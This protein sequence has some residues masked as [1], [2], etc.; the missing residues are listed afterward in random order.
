MLNIVPGQSTTF[1]DIA[2]WAAA[3][4]QI[5][6]RRALARVAELWDNVPLA[7][8]KADLS[9]FER[10]FPLHGFDPNVHKSDAAYK[11][12]RRK[13][14]AILKAYAA[15][16]AP[17]PVPSAKPL[18]EAQLSGWDDLLA[19]I[20]HVTDGVDQDALYKRQRA[21]PIRTLARLARALKLGP[22]DLTVDTLQALAK[23]LVSSERDSLM[24]AL[25]N[26]NLMRAVPE[27]AALLPEAAYP[28]NILPRRGAI[29]ELPQHIAQEIEVW[30]DVSC[31]GKWDPVAQVAMN[32]TS[33]HD[34]DK[35]RIAMRRFCATAFQEVP[36]LVNVGTIAELLTEETMT[37]VLRAWMQEENKPLSA[38][39]ITTY[40]VNIKTVAAHNELDGS[41]FD[42]LEETATVLKAGKTAGKSMSPKTKKFCA[43]LL[44]N[45]ALQ[46]KL[47]TLHVRARRV[48]AMI[49]DR[50]EKEKRDLSA[51]EIGRIRQL[52]AVAAFS[53]IETC[54]AP[55]RIERMTL[56]RISGPKADVL[57]PSQSILT[58]RFLLPEVQNK[59]KRVVAVSMKQDKR[60]GLDTLL[61]YI[62]RV[63]PLFSEA[64]E[65]EYLFPAVQSRG[66]MRKTML[67][68]WF[69]KLSRQ[70]GIPMTPHNFRHAMASMLIKKHPGQYEAVAVL[71]G[72][73]EKTVR[74][75]YAWVNERVQIETAQSLV[76]GLADA[77]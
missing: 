41:V 37:L 11:A 69:K 18:A 42:H 13:V 17:R 73:T 61:W 50:A 56:F 47:L 15:D 30:L 24:R 75:Y 72:D 6:D 66:P 67:T 2:E 70:L 5:D 54:A 40:F 63:R 1:E 29:K 45:P 28:L 21:I 4:R 36:E 58:A 22:K 27:I 25:R 46:T 10:K 43:S 74:T 34:R 39:S 48:A 3:K 64:G 16:K 12:W 52:G 19:E 49:F 14:I 57:L 31:G 59:I 68:G 20:D 62:K 77:A 8:R 7:A 55:Y 23:P 9:V 26:L 35:K 65:S 53:A 33:T 71:L 51:T 38:R 44:D 60:N 32:G 76:L